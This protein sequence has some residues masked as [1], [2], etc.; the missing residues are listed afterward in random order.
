MNQVILIGRLTRDPELKTTTA[1]TTICNFTIAVD[2][3]DKNQTTDF[4]NCT[5]FNNVGQSV[6]NYQKKGNLIAVNGSININSYEKDGEKRQATNIIAGRV[7]F[8]SPRSEQ[9]TPEHKE[10]QREMEKVIDNDLPF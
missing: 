6:Y 1:G 2:R 3:E 7:Q 4:F 9:T 10:V 8:L 5:A